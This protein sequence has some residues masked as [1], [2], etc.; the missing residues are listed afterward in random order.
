MDLI[1]DRDGRIFVIGP[2]LFRHVTSMDGVNG[3][4]AS[5]RKMGGDPAPQSVGPVR[6]KA[7]EAALTGTNV[8]FKD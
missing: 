5:I 4:Q 1:Q 3:I 7:M 6:A 8:Y 2:N